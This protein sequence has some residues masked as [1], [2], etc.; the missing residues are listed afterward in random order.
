[1]VA[2]FQ[3]LFESKSQSDIVIQVKAKKFDAH[4]LVLGTRS[5]VFLALFQSNLAETQTN[6]LKIRGIKPTVF[7]EVLRFMYTDQVEQLDELAEELLAAAE[8]YMLDLL[9]EKCVTHLAGTITV[10]NCAE[11]LQFADLHSAAGLKTIVLDFFRCRAAEVAETSSWQQLTKSANSD[12][13]REGIITICTI[14]TIYW[15]TH[16]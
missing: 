3:Q 8:R 9:K 14:C 1:M 4:K 13:L 5:P 11:K 6:T 15:W 12:L 16:H 2:Q 10:E 7:K